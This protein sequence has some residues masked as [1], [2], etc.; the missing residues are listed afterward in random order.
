M[1]AVRD[2]VPRALD[3]RTLTRDELADAVVRITKRPHLGPRL[4][5]GWGEL[6]KP[7]AFRGLLCFGPQDGRSA[8]FVRPD[9]WIGRWRD[10]ATDD[11]LREVFRRF[12]RR[13]PPRAGRRSRAGGAC[14]H[15]RPGASSR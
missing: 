7:S 8:T 2:A 3:G 12:S 4:R 9:Q 15:P 14:G 13:T 5:S 6:L 11:A 10:F 1:D